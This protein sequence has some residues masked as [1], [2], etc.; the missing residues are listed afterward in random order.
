MG[1]KSTGSIPVFPT[2]M[3]YSSNILVS[4]HVNLALSKNS[5]RNKLLFT[6]KNLFYLRCFHSF[7]VING[8]YVLDKISKRDKK[9]MFSVFFYKNVSF[10]YKVKQISTSSKKFY[11]S[12]KALKVLNTNLKASILLISTSKGLLTHKQALMYKTGGILMFLIS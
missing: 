1:L 2:K 8:L 5:L 10:F 4:N 9:I 7:G 3:N 12:L 6:K 11:I